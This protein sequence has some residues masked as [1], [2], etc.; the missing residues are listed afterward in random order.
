MRKLKG[1]HFPGRKGREMKRMDGEGQRVRV[2][3]KWPT[4]NTTS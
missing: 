3:W 2:V 4:K 1:V